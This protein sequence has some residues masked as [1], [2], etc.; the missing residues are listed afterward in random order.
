MEPSLK[1]EGKEHS[2]N[3]IV[4]M[5]GIGDL[6]AANAFRFLV[7]SAF[8]HLRAQRAGIV[9]FPLIKDNAGDLS[10]YYG[11]GDFELFSEGTYGG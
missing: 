1:N 11:V 10:V 3:Y 9:L 8:A 7:K 2:F 6:I 5:V 4:F